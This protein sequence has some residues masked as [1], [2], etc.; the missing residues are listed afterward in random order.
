MERDIDVLKKLRKIWPKSFAA[1]IYRDNRTIN[2]LISV[3]ALTT[4][5]KEFDKLSPERILGLAE[6]TNGGDE[7]VLEYIQTNPAYTYEEEINDRSYK[8]IGKALLNSL[9]NLK[10]INVIT[11][12]SLFSKLTFYEEN[13]FEVCKDNGYEMIW[14]RKS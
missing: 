13:G 9:K 11:L 10:H 12:S 7:V 4:Q 3:Y 1:D 14:K 5:Q 6:I 8:G 2:D